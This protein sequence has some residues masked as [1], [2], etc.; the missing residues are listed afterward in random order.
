MKQLYFLLII[1]IVNNELSAQTVYENP[2][3]KE[4]VY[5][6]MGKFSMLLN[7]EYEEIFYLKYGSLNLESPNTAQTKTRETNKPKS[8]FGVFGGI[9][10]VISP[11]NVSDL[12]KRGFC[13]TLHMYYD[14]SDVYSLGCDFDYGNIKLEHQGII[15][16][17][18]HNLKMFLSSNE[19]KTVKISG[20]PT[21]IV[22]F[23]PSLIIKSINKPGIK[24]NLFCGLGSYYWKTKGGEISY[25][26]ENFF[27][28][29]YIR[30]VDF[31]V[32][33][34]PD[35][36]INPGIN[37]GFFI[38]FP[39]TSNTDICL[40]MKHNIVFGYYEPVMFSIIQLGISK[41]FQKTGKFI[42]FF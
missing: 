27:I 23:S 14:F 12:I 5:T 11:G 42:P 1:I 7:K 37:F 4:Y 31:A 38:K 18:N 20:F 40:R 24:L 8:G 19:L 9:L 35:F 29:G 25:E 3:R 30:E 39:I 13:G 10:N 36:R 41:P 22:I 34:T 32:F 2:V 26:V 21:T 33:D 15:Q 17:G 6:S 28:P 16:G